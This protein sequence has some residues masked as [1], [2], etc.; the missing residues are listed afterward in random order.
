MAR[1]TFSIEEEIDLFKKAQKFSPEIDLDPNTEEVDRHPEEVAKKF[2]TNK[3][4]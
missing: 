2:A 4:Q 1:F 3:P